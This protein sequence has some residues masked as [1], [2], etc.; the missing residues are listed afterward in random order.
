MVL[1]ANNSKIL[2]GVQTVAIGST[3]TGEYSANNYD[4]GTTSIINPS[5][6]ADYIYTNAI[7][8]EENVG[9]NANFSGIGLGANSNFINNATF[10]DGRIS[11]VA[12]IKWLLLLQVPRTKHRRKFLTVQT[13]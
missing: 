13:Q 5:L 11:L 10:T 7:E 8:T 2:L 3:K 12:D 4:A 6:E 1:I 9:T